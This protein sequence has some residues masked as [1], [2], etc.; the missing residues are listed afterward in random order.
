MK[1]AVLQ[2]SDFD[3][4]VDIQPSEWYDPIPIHQFY[5]QA[6]YCF[7]FKAEINGEPVGVGTIIYHENVAWLAHILVHKNHQRKGIGQTITTYLLNHALNKGVKTVYLIATDMGAPVYSKLGFKEETEYIIYKDIEW[8]EKRALSSHIHPYTSNYK[9]AIFNLDALITGENRIDNLSLNL[10]TGFVYIQK[11]EV[12]GFY[13]P[14]LGDGLIVAKEAEAGKAFMAMRLQDQQTTAIFPKD[15]LE[16][17]R[18]MKTLNV[19]SSGC[20]KRMIYGEHRPVNFK[21]IY[22]RI[23]GNMG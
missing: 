7:S 2:P 4:L 10:N 18:F 15:N 21:Q 9:Q 11:E 17:I 6:P 23:G 19:E 1:I 5:H 8:E 13:L 14:N 16:A 20:M 12:V 3:K 22:N